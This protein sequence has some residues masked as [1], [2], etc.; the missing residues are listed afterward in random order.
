MHS[1]TEDE[2]LQLVGLYSV[3]MLVEKVMAELV[4]LVDLELG[5]RLVFE[6]NPTFW[7]RW[8]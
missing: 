5:C 2:L 3:A 1:M 8:E 4:L 7:Q 6:R